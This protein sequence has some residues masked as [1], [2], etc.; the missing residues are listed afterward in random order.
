MYWS[1]WWSYLSPELKQSIMDVIM[2]SIAW[3]WLWLWWSVHRAWDPGKH[4][5]Y[6]LSPI[7]HPRK[8]LAGIHPERKNDQ[9]GFPITNVGK[10]GGGMRVAKDRGECITVDS[11]LY[12]WLFDSW[13]WPTIRQCP[14]TLN[15][16][17]PQFSAGI[18]L[19]RR[20]DQDGFPITH[21]GKDGGEMSNGKETRGMHARNDTV[22]KWRRPCYGYAYDHSHMVNRWTDRCLMTCTPS[23]PQFV[24]GDPSFCYVLLWN[25]HVCIY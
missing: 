15:L 10:D 16:S 8:S 7:R 17:S 2:N 18:H 23:S 3:D 19:E 20:N 25:Y 6:T 1:L 9:D 24:S 12:R 13:K 14:W 21:V 11:L 22:M 4:Y 5:A